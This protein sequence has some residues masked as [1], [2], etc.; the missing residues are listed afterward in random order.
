MVMDEV[1]VLSDFASSE[2]QW[3]TVDVTLRVERSWGLSGDTVKFGLPIGSS[4][5][6]KEFI[7]GLKSMDSAIVVLTSP[8][9]FQYD[10]KLYA[11][12]MSGGLLGTTREDGR[13]RFPALENESKFLA[14]VDTLEELDAEA[15]QP[16]STVTPRR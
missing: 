8:G 1:F 14:V 6:P 16:T 5:D 9:F 2:A 10:V 7:D 13:I 12:G 15:S 11:V 3:R 4:L